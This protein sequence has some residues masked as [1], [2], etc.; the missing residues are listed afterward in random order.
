MNC[1]VRRTAAWMAVAAL[2]APFGAGLG[3]STHLASVLITASSSSPAAVE[4]AV[5]QVGGRVVDVLPIINGVSAQVPESAIAAL[6]RVGHVSRN[7]P[8]QF[9]AWWGSKSGVASAVYPS[10]VRADDAWANGV[11]GTGSTVAV[12]DTGVNPVG[13]LANAVIHSEDFSSDQDGGHDDYGHG[14][15]VAGLIAG[16]GQ[17]SSGGVK[18]VAPGSKIVNLKVGAGNGT[19]DVVRVLAA[20]QWVVN[21]K[22]TYGIDAVNLSLGTDSKQDYAVDPLNLAVERTW[23]AGIVVVVAAGNGGPTASTIL[24]PADDPFV[25]SVGSSDDRTTA[26]RGDDVVAPFSA[27]GPTAANGFAKPD[28]IAPGKSVISSR[29][30]GSTV[31]LAH[32]EARVGNDYFKG[33]GTSFSAA[34]ASGVV[35][36]MLAKAP[37]LTP[38][39]VKERLLTSANGIVNKVNVDGFGDVDA[40]SAITSKDRS[41]ANGGLVLSTGGGSLQ[42]TRGS[43]CLRTVDLSSCLG[44]ADANAIAPFNQTDYLSSSWAS[45]N[46]AS[47]SWASST[48]ASSSWASS[49]WASSSWAASNWVSSS[50]ASSSWVALAWLSAEY[51]AAPVVV[52]WDG[53]GVA[54]TPWPPPRARSAADQN[55]N[56]PD[57]W[58]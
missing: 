3:E 53:P 39:Q 58:S 9:E 22:N 37:A 50:W 44:D 8:I 36:L 2:L 16:S 32:P 35:A 11:D 6:G 41:S 21:N 17:L 13:D 34:I 10:A 43:L 42:A 29:A 31:D 18:G 28:V 55:A 4:T 27:Q 7:D 5:H 49:S 51:G 40:A 33:S 26:Q 15:F 24:K 19:T 25:I 23:K 57:D 12:I 48:W 54:V 38:D 45:S 14:T 46:W 30:P 56:R 47:S 20:L 52:A 1:V